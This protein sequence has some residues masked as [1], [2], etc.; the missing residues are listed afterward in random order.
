MYK[1]VLIATRIARSPLTWYVAG[2]IDCLL[3][4]A[5]VKFV[6]R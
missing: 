2:A 5:L 6:L 3:V 1:I 4:V